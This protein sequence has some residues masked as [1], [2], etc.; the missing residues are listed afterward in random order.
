MS[1]LFYILLQQ[2]HLQEEALGDVIDYE[3]YSQTDEDFRK[4]QSRYK[5]SHKADCLALNMNSSCT[6][7]NYRTMDK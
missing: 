3:D 6:T 7:Y 5:Q 2:K 1:L 4:V